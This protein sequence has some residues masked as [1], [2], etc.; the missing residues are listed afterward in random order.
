MGIKM[1]RI[2]ILG[3]IEHGFKVFRLQVVELLGKI[4]FLRSH[5]Y[6]HCNGEIE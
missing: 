3:K 6:G 4:L 2:I 1:V 5:K